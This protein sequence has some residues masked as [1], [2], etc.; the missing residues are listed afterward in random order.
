MDNKTAVFWYAFK[1][2]L[3]SEPLT[4]KTSINMRVLKLF[5]W[6]VG[7]LLDKEWDAFIVLWAKS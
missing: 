1:K 2:I 5:K 7:S 4:E 3:D 6:H